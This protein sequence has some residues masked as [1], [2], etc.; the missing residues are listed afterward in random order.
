[1]DTTVVSS[2]EII[3]LH[4]GG[5]Q[6]VDPELNTDDTTIEETLNII[7]INFIEDNVPI[8]PDKEAGEE[9]EPLNIWFSKSPLD[10]VDTHDLYIDDYVM[11]VIVGHPSSLT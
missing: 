10:G 5:S 11:Y 8:S 9:S 1:M 2:V 4:E 3:D 6:T 7:K